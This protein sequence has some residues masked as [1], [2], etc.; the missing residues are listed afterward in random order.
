[1]SP[2]RPLPES[3]VPFESLQLRRNPC[4]TAIPEFGAVLRKLSPLPSLAHESRISEHELRPHQIYEA[5]G[6]EVAVR[7]WWKGAPCRSGREERWLRHAVLRGGENGSLSQ[8]HRAGIPN[9]VIR[10]GLEL[11]QYLE[12][13][14]VL[15]SWSMRQEEA[16]VDVSRDLVSRTVTEIFRRFNVTAP[17]LRFEEAGI[18]P[19][20]SLVLEP[21]AGPSSR[22]SSANAHNAPS[23]GHIALS[24]SSRSP[25]PVL[26]PFARSEPGPEQGAAGKTGLRTPEE[27]GNQFDSTEVHGDANSPMLSSGRSL[28]GPTRISRPIS[29]SDSP[30]GSR[31]DG[32]AS[33]YHGSALSTAAAAA[34]AEPE[35]QSAC[36][37]ATSSE[38]KV[39]LRRRGTTKPTRL[40]ISSEAHDAEQQ[41]DPTTPRRS[42][43]KKTESSFEKWLK[44]A[45]PRQEVT[46]STQARPS[47]YRRAAT[48]ARVDFGSV[49]LQPC[50]EKS[51]H[52]KSVT[53][54]IAEIHRI[55]YHFDEDQSGF[56][57]PPEFPALFARLTKT[58]VKQ[59]DMAEVWSCWEEVDTD[60]NGQVGLEAFTA[61]YCKK[62][63]I[64]S[65][66]D[67][68][69]EEAPDDEL[70][71]HGIMIKEAS[72]RL[73]LPVSEVERVYKE[74]SK[75][76]QDGNG[77]LDKHEFKVLLNNTLSPT[78]DQEVPSKVIDRFWLEASHGSSELSFDGFCMWYRRAFGGGST[79]EDFYRGMTNRGRAVHELRGG[80]DP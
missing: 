53:R 13:N 48:S 43:Q 64:D 50:P 47:N 67:L 45:P 35:T 57:E 46:L 65:I 16:K 7:A 4:P 11:A 62:F 44:N 18:L 39:L 28:R 66:A 5:V 80:E 24:P 22:A 78:G 15:T 74:Y 70:R 51:K 21:R 73:D 29:T 79:M 77:V 71:Q 60:G 19:Q 42:N 32:P 1:M 59:L 23:R 72:R 75:L 38:V 31:Q 40:N 25:C 30:R 34:V 33:A 2:A 3:V 37:E 63:D 14:D 49:D 26:P 58:S 27:V 52:R 41:E 68:L 9:H 8:L 6:L 56:I 36:A 20:P 55:F 76:D 54:D 61:W 69:F 10:G 12:D 17:I